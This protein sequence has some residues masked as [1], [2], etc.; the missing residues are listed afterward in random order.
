MINLQVPI[1][2]TTGYGITS[3]NIWKL[4]REKN[5]VSLFPIGGG[6]SLDEDQKHLTESLQQDLNNAV[7]TD[8]KHNNLL[9][10]SVNILK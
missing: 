10:I 8:T 7:N 9:K 2:N 5:N 3:T 4:L 1:N 6:V